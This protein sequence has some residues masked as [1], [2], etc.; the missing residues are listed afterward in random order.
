LIEVN[1]LSYS[2]NVLILDMKRL[3]SYQFE[4]KNSRREGMNWFS[5]TGYFAIYRKTAVIRI[6]I[7]S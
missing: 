1:R 6:V 7:S 5:E 3:V 2:E 4:K